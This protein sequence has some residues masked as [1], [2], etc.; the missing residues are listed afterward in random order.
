MKDGKRTAF[1][2]TAALAVMAAAFIPAGCGGQGGDI[3]GPNKLDTTI[4]RRGIIPL[5]SSKPVDT[6][7]LGTLN[8]SVGFPVAQLFF[9]NMDNPVVAY[10]TL[11]D[12]LD[13]YKRGVPDERLKAMGKIL[14]DES[15]DVIGLQ[16]VMIL[17]VNGALVND[18]PAE[19][20]A[21][22]LANGG[23]DYRVFHTVMNDTVLTGKKNDST[24]TVDFREGQTFLVK[25]G[26][27]VLDSARFM[28]FD[29]LKIPVLSQPVTERGADYLRLR[30]PGGLEFQVF[31]T[32]IEVEFSAKTGSQGTELAVLAD[33]LQ[34]RVEKRGRLQVAM[35]DFNSEPDSLAHSR[36]K[37]F[38]FADTFKGPTDQDSGTTCCV[39]G[40]ALWNADTSFSNRRIDYIMARGMAGSL[41]SRTTVKGPQIGTGGVRFLATDHRMVVAKIIAQS[42]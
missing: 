21:A 10:E 14:A 12:M 28:Y 9:K 38:G 25:P 30:S 34:I 19:L 32:H 16:E 1:F 35:G 5:D 37:T 22:I 7:D 24:L 39:A 41:E 17:K 23:P 26:F 18:F 29:L 40:S 11:T 42:P 2:L 36:L 31:N 15:L 13:H 4:D 3:T 20:K 33:S 8:M 6:L 27:T